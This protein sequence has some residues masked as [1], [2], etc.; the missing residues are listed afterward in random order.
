MG[1]VIIVRSEIKVNNKPLKFQFNS[2]K[3]AF[4]DFYHHNH[5]YYY[6]S[7]TT[8]PLPLVL[9]LNQWCILTLGLQFLDCSTPLSL[10]CTMSLV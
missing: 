10:I 7:L 8:F 9:L 1:I 3:V 6:S 2:V 5:H 4:L